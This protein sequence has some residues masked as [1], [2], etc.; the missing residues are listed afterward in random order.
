MKWT[1]E[2]RAEIGRYAATTTTAAALKQ[3]QLTYPTLSKQTAH[4]LKKAYLKEKEVTNKEVTI[5]KSRKC[6]QPKLLPEYIMA[7]TIQTVKALH[8]KGAPV[9]SPV[10]N[11][12]A[13]D[14]VVVQDR[15]LLTEYGGHLVFSDQWVRNILNEIM[16]TEKNMVRKIATTS[17]VPVSP[18]MLKEEK[19]TFQRKIQELVTWHKIPKELIT[20]FDQTSLSYITIG[21]TTLEFSGVQSV[22]VEGKGKGKQITGTFSITVASKFLSLKLIYPGKIQR[23]HPKGI[24]FPDEFDVTHSKNHWSNETL[25]IQHL[26]NIII[27]YFEVIREEPGLLENRKCLLTY[28]VFKVQTTEMYREHLDENNIAYVQVPPNLTHIF[29]PLVLNVN[30]FTKSF[31]KSRSHKWY[32]KE[33]TN[34]LNKGKNVHQIDIDTKLSKMKPIH[35]RWLISLYEKL[36]N[37]NKIIKSAFEN[38]LVMEAIDN[39]EIPDEDPFKPLSVLKHIL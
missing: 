28:N 14:V 11:A 10:I 12:T 34:G 29:Q 7:K 24:P 35:A 19:F 13:K 3:Y 9:S 25:A 2:V 37:S 38:A 1:S 23:C 17:K 26:D 20:N 30:A 5:L 21:N 15:C 36:R 31:L 33:V 16:Q 39:K 22:T 18:G 27:P 6:G 4:E 8:L 32:T